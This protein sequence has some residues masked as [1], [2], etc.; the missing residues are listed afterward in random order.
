MGNFSK[1]VKG[2][3]AA[4]IGGA[5]NGLAVTVVDPEHFLSAAG[6]KQLAAIAAV[7]GLSHAA[8]YLKQSPTVVAGAGQPGMG[9]GEK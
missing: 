6:W 8:A 9:E 7:G 3:A 1:W 4:A 5:I 2:L